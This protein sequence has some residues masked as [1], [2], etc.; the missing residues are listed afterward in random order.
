MLLNI[1]H[2]SIAS[3]KEVA[4]N[5]YLESVISIVKEL[6]NYQQQDSTLKKYKNDL[7]DIL[8]CNNSGLDS[9][10]T[11]NFIQLLGESYF[12]M[13][14]LKKGIQI[15]KI[16][17]KYNQNTPDFQLANSQL[18]AWFEV[19]TLSVV[20]GDIGVDRALE[21]RFQAMYDLEKQKN[22][23]N[24][25]LASTSIIQPYG[26][27]PY[28]LGLIKSIL[29]TLHNKFLNN[30]KSGQFKNKPT[31]LVLNFAMLPPFKTDSC[32]LRPAYCDDYLF[33]KAISGDLWMLSFAKP[34][35][36]IFG[37]PEFEGKPCI[38]GFSITN[39]LLNEYEVI[40]GIIFMIFPMQNKPELWGT[41]R[42]K[43]FHNWEN[44]NKPI[45][46]LL[47]KLV[48]SNWNDELDTNGFQLSKKIL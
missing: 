32:V 18:D 39:G 44:T 35:M 33:P 20:D 42:S 47:L 8:T 14:C 25:V 9:K 29:E 1:F 43:D 6:E 28:T 7:S 2:K 48:S 13:T 4:G 21:E 17:E 22:N 38:E 30:F 37:Q 23:G 15:K 11:N 10:L 40:D 16:K 36:L 26:E 34:G 24:Q 5:Y 41:F 12:Y 46:R 3:A 31:F 19:K 27:K 45:K